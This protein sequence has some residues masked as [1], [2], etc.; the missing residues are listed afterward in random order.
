MFGLRPRLV[1]IILLGVAAIVLLI[2]LTVAWSSVQRWR[3]IL[4]VNEAGVARLGGKA[5]HARDRAEAAAG[6][7]PD[8]AMA[9]LP[10]IEPGSAAAEARLDRLTAAIHPRDRAVVETTAAFDAALRGGAPDAIEGSD[11]TLIRHLQSLAKGDLPPFPSLDAGD[12]PQAA[13]LSQAAQR[14]ALAAWKAGNREQLQR[15]LGLVALAEP[16]HPEAKEIIALLALLDQGLSKASLLA[17]VAGLGDRGAALARRAAALSPERSTALF[18]A[19]PDALRTAEEN[20]RLAAAGALGEPGDSLET[21][22]NKALAQP[23]PAALAGAFKRTLDE[24]RI[25]L[26]KQLIE[27]SAEPQRRDLRIALAMHQGDVMALAALQPERTDLKLTTTTPIGRPGQVSFHL[28]SRSGMVPRSGELRARLG[29][30]NVEPEHIRR[31]GS[32]VVI[33]APLTSGTVDLEVRFDD[34]TVFSGSVDL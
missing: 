28:A 6:L 1:G 25:D 20:E 17:V 7:L 8:E 32:L 2:G 4:A 10:S 14:H 12:P 33:D 34:L 15:G 30:E 22:A 3:A 11:G 19:I 31:W 27:K 9:V 21:L 23:T 16:D 5:A 18:A 13:I 24:G 26:A 29:G